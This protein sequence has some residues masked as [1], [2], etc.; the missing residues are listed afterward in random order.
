MRTEV[1]T[2]AYR[3]GAR[4]GG[5]AARRT[6]TRGG[7]S[8]AAGARAWRVPSARGLVKRVLACGALACA[9]LGGARSAS[10]GDAVVLQSGTRLEGRV[11]SETA[12][13]VVIELAGGRTRM[14]VGRAQVASI[15]RGL[16]DAP[17]AAPAGQAVR[18][19]WYL[20]KAAERTVG[21]RHLM[22]LPSDRADRKGW[23]FEEQLTFLG[24]DRLPGVRV[25][26][27]EETTEDFRPVHLHYGER[28]EG[29]G[30]GGTPGY[31]VFRAGPVVDGVWNATVREGTR[32]RTLELKGPAGAR[33][34]LALREALVRATPRTAG[35]V[36][37]PLLDP[38]RGE[39][40]TVR[41]GFTTLDAG[42]SSVRIDVLRVE[43]GDRGLESRWSPGDPPRCTVEDV[44]PGVVAVPASR[45][46]AEAALPAP[47]AALDPR[48]LLRPA[49]LPS[50]PK[51]EGPRVLTLAD[52]GIELTLPGPGWVAEP[53]AAQADDVGA[54][55]VARVA[56]R[57]DATDVRI[58]WDPAGAVGDAGAAERDLLA[59]LRR[60]ARDLRVETPRAAVAD[61]VWRM[62]VVGTVRRESLWTW[63]LCADRG[64]GR[65]TVLVACP[66]PAVKDVS[67]AVEA[68]LTSFRRL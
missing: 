53:L 39:L 18:D 14:T 19:E 43:D 5:P 15:E 17:A 33:S 65:I 40:R 42:A 31:D 36:E 47:A 41:A 6:A 34:P 35:L 58:E 60:V 66:E 57:L 2:G 64:R 56:S 59:R 22:M 11:V 29:A 8:A 12:D 7:R 51:E 27:I 3:T 21:V 63:V 30:N 1:V 13:A 26:R 46:Q 38:A 37:V 55:V 24:S 16:P 52:V 44:A 50:A 4:A 49:A 67:P 9:A 45:A 61:G 48:T 20:L 68:L 54:R 32:Q 25:E 28:G 62:R 10:A 23:R